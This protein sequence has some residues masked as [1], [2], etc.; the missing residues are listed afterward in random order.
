M[1]KL[2]VAVTARE[3]VRERYLARL[4]RYTSNPGTSPAARNGNA[5]AVHT[6]CAPAPSTLLGSLLSAWAAG[7]SGFRMWPPV[8]KGGASGHPR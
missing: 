1:M 4:S 3:V 6:K 5:A 8:R 2:R 7:G